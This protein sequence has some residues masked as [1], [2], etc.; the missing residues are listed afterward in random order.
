MRCTWHVSTWHLSSYEAGRNCKQMSQAVMK[1][2][3]FLHQLPPTPF[4][5]WEQYAWQRNL[6][7]PLH[8]CACLTWVN[9]HIM[10]FI[11]ISKALKVRASK[12]QA[13]I[14][15]KRMHT[16]MPRYPRPTV[17]WR[18]QHNRTNC[19]ITVAHFWWSP[20]HK[21]HKAKWEKAETLECLDFTIGLK[22]LQNWRQEVYTKH[23]EKSRSNLRW[24]CL[25]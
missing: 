25:S 20:H 17:A 18:G 23:G 8:L 3:V 13:R 4:T 2:T 16:K 9:M 19:F 15:W 14:V 11:A 21:D 1:P 6:P 12:K 24:M 10:N 5:Q 7:K 22:N